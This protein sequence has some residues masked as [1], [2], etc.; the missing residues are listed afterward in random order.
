[1]ENN[2]THNEQSPRERILAKIKDHE[3]TMRPKAFFTLKVLALA[4]LSLF[5]LGLTV[6]LCNFILFA[7]RVS[8]HESL[9]GFGARG[10]LTFWRLFPWKYF[11]LY[12]FL[13]LLLGSLIRCFRFG[14]RRPLAYLLGG[15]FLLIVIAGV[16][17]D[18][19][20]RF[21]DELLDRADHKL[22]PAP[23][24]DLY[25]RARHM[26]P[27][28]HNVYLSKVLSIEG[29]ILHVETLTEGTTTALSVEVDPN[30]A[31]LSHLV[32]GDTVFVFGDE[33]SGTVRAVGIQRFI[34]H[35]FSH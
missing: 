5:V 1:M 3:V 8:G 29:N 14:Y 18:R 35:R 30:D 15:S 19:G 11:L 7:L 21:N 13:L 17:I 16:L 33:A 26:I 24:G 6:F 27:Q 23:F 28:D 20:T 12:L 31:L 10:H 2:P 32:V 25:G 34:P 9:L 22:L 4:L